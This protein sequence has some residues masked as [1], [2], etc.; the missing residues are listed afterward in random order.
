MSLTRDYRATANDNDDRVPAD[1]AGRQL[2]VLPRSPAEALV[3]MRPP[4]PP[5]RDEPEPDPHPF[6][7]MFDGL[8]TF[9][10]LIAC[11]AAVAFYWVK[12]KFDQP[13]PLKTSTVV[14]I[15]RGEGVSAIAE[16][17]QR[18]GVIDD[19]RLFMTS[20]IYF[21]YLKGQGTLKAGEYEFPKQATM[22]QVLDT[23]ARV[24]GRHVESRPAPRRPGDPPAL[25]GSA[26]KARRVL[27]WRPQLDSLETIVET[28]WAWHRARPGAANE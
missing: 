19:R 17:L 15:P 6:L 23:V 12:V 22:R 3:P 20:I 11:A 25:V 24:T 16:R 10:F 18:D 27:G 2:A 26:E 13:G 21:K 5:E 14:V 4:E 1:A 7:R 9:I 28:A 8:V